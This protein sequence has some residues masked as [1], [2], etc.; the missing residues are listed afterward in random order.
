MKAGVCIKFN[1]NELA[2][3]DVIDSY[4]R[5]ITEGQLREKLIYLKKGIRLMN[6]IIKSGY[7]GEDFIN[8]SFTVVT[9]WTAY[10]IPRFLKNFLLK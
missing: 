3:K 8:N 9:T 4:T 6:P 7:G 5:S 10:K 2:V 1:S